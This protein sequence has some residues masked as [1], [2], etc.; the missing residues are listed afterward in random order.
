MG[1]NNEVITSKHR[2][3]NSSRISDNIKARYIFL[4]EM[5]EPQVS[6]TDFSKELSSDIGNSWAQIS[7]F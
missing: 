3:V 6:I 4:R 2:Q 5:K 1:T 7:S